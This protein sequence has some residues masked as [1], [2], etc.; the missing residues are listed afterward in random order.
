MV[1]ILITREKATMQITVI[2]NGE[3]AVNMKYTNSMNSKMPIEAANFLANGHA[4]NV[5]RSLFTG[6]SVEV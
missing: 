1:G 5:G 2:S 6:I 4:C 3:L